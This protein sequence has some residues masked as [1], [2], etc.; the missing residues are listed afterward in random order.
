T[1]QM[2]VRM[3][4]V[5]C[6]VQWL[7]AVR[8]SIQEIDGDGLSTEEQIELT[9]RFMSLIPRMV[10]GY[11]LLGSKLEESPGKEQFIGQ[12]LVAR[13]GLEESQGLG[14]SRMLRESRSALENGEAPDLVN[15]AFFQQA[16]EILDPADVGALKKKFGS[17]VA[18][19]EDSP[20]QMLKMMT[21]AMF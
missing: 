20:L 13:L 16:A 2:R 9:K 6:G 4:T 1:A 8:D 14:L 18:K 15:E 10:G 21:M 12:V 11:E 17:D 19:I 5:E 3:P 7:M